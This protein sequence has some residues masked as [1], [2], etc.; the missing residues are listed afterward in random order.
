MIASMPTDAPPAVSVVMPLHNGAKHCVD[1]LAS[2][3]GQSLPPLE[4]IVV[5]DGSTDGSADL[6]V[7]A[8]EATHD[9]P[10]VRIVRQENAG[11]SAARNHGARLARGDLLAFIDQDDL[12]HPRHLEALSAPFVEDERVGWVFGDFDEVD[13]D[14]LV[15]TRCFLAAAGVNPERRSLAELVASDLMV[16]PSAS[17]LRSSAFAQV[18]GFDPDLQG[19]EDDDLFI[20]FFRH[21]WLSTFVPEVLTSFRTHASSSSAGERFQRSRLRFLDKLI[22][23]VPDD[24]RMN[25]FFVGDL[26]VPRLFATTLTEYCVALRVGDHEGAEQLA[27]TAREISDRCG[28]PSLR[29][30][31]EL[32]L[33][34]R[35]ATMTRFLRTYEAVPRRLRP[36]IHPALSLR[37]P[38]ARPR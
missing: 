17:V 34:A 1:A 29:R 36:P 7:A 13:T 16:L 3:L 28:P 31:I 5:D 10:E 2:V 18:G 37:H 25:R 32:W 15:V 30:R 20:R 26:V 12:W 11:Q 21:C 22:A 24:P 6:L 19:Y 27:A 33:L 8:V 14:D 23:T 4:V 9:R 38:G 35:P